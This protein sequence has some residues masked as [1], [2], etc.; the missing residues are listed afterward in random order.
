MKDLI[1]FESKW[2]VTHWSSI[3]VYIWMI[4]EKAVC[5]PERKQEI[6]VRSNLTIL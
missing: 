1:L 4:P 6:W 3:F 5:Y 2:K